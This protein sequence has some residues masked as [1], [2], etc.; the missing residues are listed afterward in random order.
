MSENNI[1]FPSYIKFNDSHLSIQKTKY[2]MSIDF[3]KFYI[4]TKSYITRT[5]RDNVKH[6]ELNAELAAKL[7]MI[8]DYNA[9]TDFFAV[10]ENERYET[11]YRDGWKVEYKLCY[12]ETYIIQGEL[13]LIFKESPLE[14]VLNLLKKECPLIS[15]L[16][17]F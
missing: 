11:G 1:L 5:H 13:G 4:E 7:Q 14:K 8:L 15:E 2:Q 16:K 3:N 17:H 9:V 10:P 12:N 6:Y